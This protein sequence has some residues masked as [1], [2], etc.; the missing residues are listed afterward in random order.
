MN[1]YA[2]EPITLLNFNEL[3][4]WTNVNPKDPTFPLSINTKWTA[5]WKADV[6]SSFAWGLGDK[7]N[8]ATGEWEDVVLNPYADA[9]GY[10]YGFLEVR[11]A[12]V[13][14]SFLV[15]VSGELTPLDIHLIDFN[16]IFLNGFCAD[17]STFST[18][19]HF[20]MHVKM[21]WKTCGIG[22]I[23]NLIKNGWNLKTF[24]GDCEM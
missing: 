3:Y 24:K 18:S 4:S 16:M 19:L 11:S 23:E 15:R 1:D 5:G 2:P 22:L 6:K 8:V 10:G 7:I 13:A 20:E 9:Y 14:N 17:I 21:G 12:D